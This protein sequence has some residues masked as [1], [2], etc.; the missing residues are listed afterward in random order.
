MSHS[1]GRGAILRLA[2]PE[3]RLSRNN[4]E[5]KPEKPKRRKEKSLGRSLTRKDEAEGRKIEEIWQTVM[6]PRKKR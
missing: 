4:E 1:G 5:D 6:V 2:Q 3:D